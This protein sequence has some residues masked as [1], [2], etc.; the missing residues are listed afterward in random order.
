MALDPA[1]FATLTDLCLPKEAHKEKLADLVTLLMG[2]LKPTRFRVAER[3]RFNLVVQEQTD[4]IRDFTLKLRRH[5]QTCEFGD[6]LD[7]HLRDRFVVGVRSEGIRKRL[8]TEDKNLT[9]EQIIA[10]A[11]ATEASVREATAVRGAQ[12]GSVPPLNAVRSTRGGRDSGRTGQMGSTAA[13]SGV[14]LCYGCTSST[15][16]YADCP[17]REM[18][19]HKCGR[20]GHIAKACRQSQ[21]RQSPHG[22]PDN[23]RGGGRGGG[24]G[25]GGSA[26][27]G[28]R[29]GGRGSGGR[30]G[31]RHGG[32]SHAHAIDAN[33]VYALKSTGARPRSGA[34][35]L[36][37]APRANNCSK[38]FRS[39]VDTLSVDDGA[40]RMTLELS[41]NGKPICMEFDTGAA[42]TLVPRAMVP[43]LPVRRTMQKLRSA[44]GHLMALMGEAIVDVR[45]GGAQKKLKLFVSKDN[46][47]ALCGRSWIRALFGDTWLNTLKAGKPEM[48]TVTKVEP[49]SAAVQ[50]VLDRFKDTFFAP[51][52]GVAKNFEARLTLKPDAVPKFVKA[53]PVAYALLPKLSDTLDRMVADGQLQKVDYAEWASAMVAVQKPDGSIRVC[54]DYRPINAQLQ[55]PQYP[56]PNAHDLFHQMRGGVKFSKLDILQAYTHLP[57]HRD[58]Q[59]LTTINTPK[60]LYKW[61]RLPFGVASSPAIF[62]A[63]VERALNG[64]DGCIVYL[65]D[66]LITG[67]TDAEHLERLEKVL[68]ALSDAGFR[69]RTDKCV[70]MT[71]SVEYLGHRLDRHGIHTQADKVKAMIDAPEPKNLEGL[72]SWLGAAQYYAKFVPQFSTIVAPLNALRSKDVKWRW[73]DVERNALLALKSAL[74]ST[75]VLTHYTPE[76]PIKLDT[77][78]S[79]VGLGAVIS[80]I[81]PDGSE[82]PIAYASRTLNATERA[83]GQ[84]EREAASIIFGV[85][86]FYKYLAGRK[87]LL[88]TDHQP[89]VSIFNPKKPLPLH[90]TARL[91]RWA[92]YLM[93][94]EFDIQ[95]RRSGE[96]AN[97]DVL[98]R[99]PLPESALEMYHSDLVENLEI[100]KIQLLQLN[101][102]QLDA[103]RVAA[104]TEKDQLLVRVSKYVVNGWPKTV[105]ADVMPYFRHRNELSMERGV[106]L[107]SGRVVVP[108]AMQP[109]VLKL[110]HAGHTGIVKTKALARSYVY[111]PS[112]DVRY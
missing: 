25:G 15:H 64:I 8:L 3:Y 81:L 74:S 106:L 58:S 61:L 110:L 72:S 56:M 43:N 18:T 53:R 107:M 42:V 83:W 71:D 29:G 87:F 63:S 11:E 47:P 55:I 23:G 33:G 20:T 97:C 26:G 93:S 38:Q 12:P 102:V 60:G 91:Q 69:G 80:H 94:F 89:L 109:E 62:Q 54:G 92:L 85:R 52:L 30:G 16:L 44:S 21:S 96:H 31:F 6:S 50:T 111:W 41:V 108:R 10:I 45:Y 82:K 86:H 9:F 73:G 27:R 35:I 17:C 67:S 14:R 98:S 1:T 90:S 4:S 7:E 51:G 34:R 112:L 46:V 75:D 99:F 19:C 100:S 103:R 76:L 49:P 13:Q 105:P 95:Y 32:S 84:I 68:K 2:H 78:A 88:V 39:E 22:P 65:D 24:G 59:E 66:I 104:L 77:D 28:R 36:E 70:F 5:A 37:N 79:S 40:P 57:L 48:L 101:D